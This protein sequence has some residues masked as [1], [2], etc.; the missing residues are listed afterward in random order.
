[1]TLLRVEWWGKWWKFIIIY[2]SFNNFYSLH[3]RNFRLFYYH[4]ICWSRFF[5]VFFLVF[6]TLMGD[7]NHDK[8]GL[9][10]KEWVL[11]M[12]GMK[13]LHVWPDV[14]FYILATS[15]TLRIVDQ[16]ISLCL[17]PVIRADQVRSEWQ[18]SPSSAWVTSQ[19]SAHESRSWESEPG[20]TEFRH[21]H[22]AHHNQCQS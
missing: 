16:K 15:A 4:F 21:Q 19:S 10:V 1:M 8:Q 22:Q 2:W 20:D 18:V 11:I 17:H 14:S 5:W 7:C 3:R 6:P 9:R 13:L 12:E